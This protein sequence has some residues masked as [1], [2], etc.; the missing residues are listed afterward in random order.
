[1]SEIPSPEPEPEVP[2]GDGDDDKGD[3]GTSEPM[4]GGGEQA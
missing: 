2:G 4:P 3:E 1:M